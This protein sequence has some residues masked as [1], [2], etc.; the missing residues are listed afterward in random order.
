MCVGADKIFGKIQ[1]Y[2][3]VAISGRGVNF[4]ERLNLIR[5]EPEFFL[6]FSYGSVV[7][8][9]VFLNFSCRYLKQFFF[10]GIAILLYEIHEFFV[11][12]GKDCRSASVFHDFTFARIAV[13]G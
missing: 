1:S 2:D 4:A 6:E 11:F 8:I 5:L 3:F 9:F 7:R 13:F 10:V 12:H